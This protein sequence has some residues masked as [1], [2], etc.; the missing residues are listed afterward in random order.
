MTITITEV[1]NAQSLQGDNTRL[2]V[3]INHPEHGWIPYTIDPSD[4]DST[5]DNAAIAALIGTDFTAYVA[6]TQAE[7]NA[8]LAADVRVERDALLAATDWMASQDVT[9]SDDWR[10]YRQALRDLPAQSGFPD[11]AFPTPPS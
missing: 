4:A 1:R 3:E 7:L 6:P 2:D 11:A 10:T 5:I 9:M 8:A